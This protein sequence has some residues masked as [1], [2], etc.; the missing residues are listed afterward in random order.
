MSLGGLQKKLP[1]LTKV[2]GSTFTVTARI[3]YYVE[4]STQQRFFWQ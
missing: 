2:R 3:I 1:T 4:C